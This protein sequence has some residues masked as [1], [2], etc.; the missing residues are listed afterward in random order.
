MFFISSQDIFASCSSE[1]GL[2]FFGE[3]PVKTSSGVVLYSLISSSIST[4]GLARGMTVGAPALSPVDM[5]S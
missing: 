5:H 3:D 1:L 4:H 2:Y